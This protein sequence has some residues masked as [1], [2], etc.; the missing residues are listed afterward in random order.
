MKLTRFLSLVLPLAVTAA[1]AQ[2]APSNQPQHE[3]SISLDV[4]FGIRAVPAARASIPVGDKLRIVAPRVGD[5]VNYIWT[6]NGR[7]IQGAPDSNVLTLDHVVSSD[8]GSYAC[9]FSTATTLPQP[10][11]TLILG[12]GPVDRLLN[13]STRTVVGPGGEDALTTGFVVSGGATSKKL[14]IR[15]IGPSLAL[16][17]VDN[18]LP[19]PVLKI[20][21]ANGRLYEN[22]FAY[23]AV[24]GGLTYETDLAQ[25]LA[26]TGAFPIP[27]GN[28]DVVEMKPFEPGTYTA[29]VTSGDG[30]TGTVLLEI[31]EVP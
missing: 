7:A 20:Y 25:S 1:F 21:D 30:S 26:K 12:V 18:A 23:P 16:F 9:L 6:K 29:T 28:R 3:T 2:P 11:Q 22:G 8:A 17:G 4:G 24:I 10:S 13:I 5:G 27:R 31:Y 15:A 19:Q 14:I